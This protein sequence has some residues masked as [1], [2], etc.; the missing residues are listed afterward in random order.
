MSLRSVRTAGL[1]ALLGGCLG[2]AA[3]SEWGLANVL[4][5]RTERPIEI[6]RADPK[7]ATV[8][9]KQEP[10]QQVQ[11]LNPTPLP[12][13][14]D[15][16]T[17]GSILFLPLV[18][19]SEHRF[20]PRF[21]DSF[22]ETL[23][24]AALVFGNGAPIAP[25]LSRRLGRELGFTEDYGSSSSLTLDHEVI[26]AAAKR[27]GASSV[28]F[29]ELASDGELRLRAFDF[30][31][32]AV[33]GWNG[34]AIKLWPADEAR[35]DY[36]AL[37]GPRLLL[38]ALVASGRAGF[39][40]PGPSPASSVARESL[41]LALASIQGGSV[42]EFQRAEMALVSLARSHPGWREPWLDLATL[43]FLR[44]LSLGTPPEAAL[45]REGPSTARHI[46][47]ALGSLDDRQ[48]ARLDAIDWHFVPRDARA[49]ELTSIVR[50]LAKD[51][52]LRPA[53]AALHPARS[54][55]G[56]GLDGLVAETLFEALLLAKA[57]A[58]GEGEG[59]LAVDALNEQLS[60]AQRMGSGPLLAALYSG[61]KA[62]GDWGGERDTSLLA[63][64]GTWYAGMSVART[65]CLD[66]A[67]AS[68][69]ACF[70]ALHRALSIYAPAGEVPEPALLS[71]DSQWYASLGAAVAHLFDESLPVLEGDRVPDVEGAR[72]RW[73]R[74]Q[75]LA[76][77]ELT[78]TAN[79][80]LAARWTA[81]AL[82]TPAELLAG[83]ARLQ[84][85]TPIE[86]L[87][88][89]LYIEP[90]IGR[91]R[92]KSDE[93][94]PYLEILTPFDGFATA[95]ALHS[96]ISRRDGNRWKQVLAQ[97]DQL[98]RSDPYDARWCG[99]W[100]SYFRASDRTHQ[101]QDGI[102]WLVKLVPRTVEIE[103][104]L[105]E[106]QGRASG[107]AEQE[108]RHLA[109]ALDERLDDRLAKKYVESVEEG[110]YRDAERISILERALAEFPHRN[111]LQSKLAFLYRYVG[112]LDRARKLAKSLLGTGEHRDACK[113]LAFAEANG[114]NPPGMI[115]ILESCANTAKNKW[116]A[117]NLYAV[118][119][120]VS[121]DLAEYDRAAAFYARA[122]ERVGGAG[123][124]LNGQALSAEWS[125]DY[126]AAE[127]YLESV[128]R[129]YK[130]TLALRRLAVLYLRQGRTADARAA[131]ER[132]L[133][134]KAPGAHEYSV[135]A[136]IHIREGDLQ[137]LERY[138]REQ[139]N[140][141]SGLALAQAYQDIGAPHQGLGVLD[142]LMKDAPDVKS[143]ALVKKA[144]ILL[145]L[146]RYDEVIALWEPLRD[147][148]KQ[149][150][151]ARWGLIRAYARSGRPERARELAD[152]YARHYPRHRTVA[153]WRAII[154]EAEGRK[155]DA[156]KW[157]AR[158]RR[159]TPT[160]RDDEW[161]HA[162][163]MLRVLRREEKLGRPARGGAELA[164]MVAQAEYV[165]N[166]LHLVSEAWSLVARLRDAAGDAEGASDARRMA[167]TVNP[168]RE[169]RR[170]ARAN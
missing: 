81:P 53:I 135:I 127:K 39:S 110:I 75:W 139:G 16:A 103:L 147:D 118:A 71:D 6:E 134:R 92:F 140:P 23:A 84:L 111:D 107:E 104:S 86:T 65:L 131:I 32:A 9:T 167:A 45:L 162:R 163:L 169:S 61:R 83:N 90:E 142:E 113:T 146:E 133:E 91:R 97:L 56:F 122:R 109:A 12:P 87:L 52:I 124:V 72:G 158:Y 77:A 21:A 68:Q 49:G 17:P 10:W 34:L 1:L 28:V 30:G 63:V 78:R 93:Y 155:A 33:A 35:V 5:W 55:D 15:D 102:D 22:G 120:A 67:G 38:E 60:E 11:R 2:L 74:H 46:A 43:R 70:A 88:A 117:A 149:G 3:S 36:R 130:S 50:R 64:P 144:S 112:D 168:I 145:E 170:L 51:D 80:V 76:V 24:A 136:S 19:R 159:Q 25:E 128:H 160:G 57:R 44:P 62:G 4:N 58:R 153:E 116:H 151:W 106:L 132:V 137:G 121:A 96:G 40:L 20:H 26:Q 100:R 126:E 82:A 54:R 73:A 115:E 138:L 85:S 157:Y 8:S 42:S 105:A 29:P 165:A 114:G 27:V 143:S 101:P 14:A 95:L 41:A 129:S 150:S 94:E 66:L 69:Q 59:H 79:D 37:D 152:E 156:L 18:N 119:G 161:G 125:G 164:D 108:V 166:K 13:Q 47:R 141:Q 99:R 148:P 154:A 31:G 48:R 123:W 7:P 98:N 89:S